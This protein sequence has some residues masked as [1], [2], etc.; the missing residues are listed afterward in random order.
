MRGRRLSWRQDAR[1]PAA[2]EY[3]LITTLILTC[4]SAVISSVVS[5]IM[6]CQVAVLSEKNTLEPIKPSPVDETSN[7]E[8]PEKF[9]LP[10]AEGSSDSKVNKRDKAS[11]DDKFIDDDRK[12]KRNHG[13]FSEREKS[14]LLNCCGSRIETLGRPESTLQPTTRASDINRYPDR[15]GNRPDD[16]Y[17]NWQSV[18]PSSSTNSGVYGNSGNQPDRR[19]GYRP[20]YHDSEYGRPGNKPSYN[21]GYGYGGYGDSGS[22]ASQGFDLSHRPGGI[23]FT[24]SNRHPG[25]GIHGVLEGQDEFPAEGS[26]MKPNIQTQKAVALKALAGVALIGA[27][28]ALAANPALIPVG[29]LA[30]GRKRRSI[31]P[32][33]SFNLLQFPEQFI[34]DHIPGVYEDDEAANRFWESPQCVARLTC[35]VQ[36]EYLKAIS[37]N[38]NLRKDVQHRLKELIDSQILSVDYVNQ[39][40]KMLTKIARNATPTNGKCEIFACNFFT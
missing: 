20:S 34:R 40:M 22:F 32:D 10:L 4:S 38:P 6:F 9:V 25:Y 39:S 21:Y 18:R 23:F 17:N 16:R 3:V 14:P 30:A 29:V 31:E 5:T 19:F 15:Y 1:E 24:G 27:A 36:N 26:A 33:Q 2:R 8:S 12:D 35:E 28:A 37:K 7:D 11:K 13:R